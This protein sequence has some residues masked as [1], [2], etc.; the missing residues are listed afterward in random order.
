M[1]M[2]RENGRGLVV[3][4][5]PQLVEE[6]CESVLIVCEEGLQLGIRIGEMAVLC[7]ECRKLGL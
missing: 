5:W 6:K 7:L 4:V 2:E 1:F 3:S